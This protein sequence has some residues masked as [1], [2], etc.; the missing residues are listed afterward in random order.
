MIIRGLIMLAIGV[1]GILVN[2][3]DLIWTAS[4]KVTI[5]FAIIAAAG[6]AYLVWALFKKR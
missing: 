2:E 4:T 1:A 6:L 5:I 3:F